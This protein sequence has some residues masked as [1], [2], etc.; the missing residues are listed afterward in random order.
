M[1]GGKGITKSRMGRVIE[2]FHRTHK[3]GAVLG[4][5]KR[6]LGD[7]AVREAFKN[8]QRQYCKFFPSPTV[9]SCPNDLWGGS[10]WSD[11][12]HTLLGTK[13]WLG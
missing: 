7:L 9:L 5:L 8:S 11:V 10:S 13:F 3:L 6:F 1:F 12:L 4:G 2:G